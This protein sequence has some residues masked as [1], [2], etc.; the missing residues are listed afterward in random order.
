MQAAIGTHVIARETVRAPRK[1]MLVKY[2]DGDITRK[3]KLLEKQRE[4]GKRIKT[5]RRVKM[6]QGAL[7]AT[8]GTDTSTDIKLDK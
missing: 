3:R 4:G 7:I 2:Y 5:I 1:D 8:L 6:P